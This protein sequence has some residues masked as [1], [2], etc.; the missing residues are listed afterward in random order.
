MTQLLTL[1]ETAD[2]IRR[3]PS[4]L[5]WL[6]AAGKAPKSGLLGGRRMFRVEDVDAWIEAAFAEAS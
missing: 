3:S 5:R 6:I 1:E 2:R 4:Q